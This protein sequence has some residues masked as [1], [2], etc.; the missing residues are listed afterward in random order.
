[1]LTKKHFNKI[2]EI[3]KTHH[4]SAYGYNVVTK[5][6]IDDLS[7][8]FKSDNPNFNENKFKEACLKE[9]CE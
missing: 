2:A 1:M 7:N 4:N 3:I 8:Y 9:Y 6:F 5:K